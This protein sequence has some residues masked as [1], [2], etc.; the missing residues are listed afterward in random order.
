MKTN[1]KR[2]IVACLLAAASIISGCGGSASKP[3]R[4][5]G[6]VNLPEQSDR[7]IY[8]AYED[9][10]YD[11]KGT[12][13]YRY[14]LSFNNREGFMDITR[15]TVEDGGANVIFTISCRRPIEKYRDDG[16]TGTKGWWLQMMDIYIDKDGASG[17]KSGYT[18]SLPGRQVEFEGKNGWE[19]CVLVTPTHSRTVEKIL[20]DRTSDMDLVHQRNDIIVPHRVY[21]Q[22]Y[23]FVVYVPKHEVG[24]PQPG[25]GYQVL[26]VP[27]SEANLAYGHF[28]NQKIGK[29]AGNDTFGGGTDFDGNPNVL[30]ILAPSDKEQYRILS[31]YYSAPYGGEN[32]Y[33]QVPFVYDQAVKGSLG[34]VY[35]HK[36]GPAETYRSS[37]MA[38]PKAPETI[39]FSSPE[40]NNSGDREKVAAKSTTGSEAQPFV[41]NNNV[42]IHSFEGGF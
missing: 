10:R 21:P 41:P 39:D 37:V 29:F 28:Q 38:P 14:P 6:V 9:P 27:Y 23:T 16:S 15:F 25:W 20:E 8:F 5:T 24:T 18:K 30:D 1:K 35:S 2:L 31:N 26:M 42:K 7:N 3:V 19:K 36:S 4:E 22:G 17:K 12:G 34:P 40:K 13:R 33:V 11:D 32:R